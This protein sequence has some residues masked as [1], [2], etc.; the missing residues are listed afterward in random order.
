MTDTPTPAP[1]KD[2]GLMLYEPKMIEQIKKAL[3]SS[4]KSHVDRFT[5]IALTEFRKNKELQK[6]SPT[7]ILTSFMQSCQI[8]L[9]IGGVGGQCY[10][11]PFKQEC[12]LQIGYRGMIELAYRSG[13][14][15]SI[16]PSA[17]Y[18]NDVF[19][20][21]RG[22]DPKIIHEPAIKEPK[23]AILGFY[24][25]AFLKDGASVFQYMNK[26]EINDHRKKFSKGGNI[27]DIHYEAMALKTVMKKLFKWLPQCSEIQQAMEIEALSDSFIQID[28]EAASPVD[29]T[30]YETAADHAAALID[31]GDDE[32]VSEPD[33]K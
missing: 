27:W 5:R 32:D 22:S 26:D 15:R 4:Q 25:V 23:G 28:A 20:I 19:S 7:S 6:C 3:P 1:Q 9:E 8:G 16:Q 29:E 31:L 10:L 2:F 13:L 12:T 14:V 21:A 17:V 18:E 24:V 11:I 33:P 30:V